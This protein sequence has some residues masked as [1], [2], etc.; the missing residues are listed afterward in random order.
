MPALGCIL[1]GRW[2]VSR[3]GAGMRWS[4]DCYDPR[5]RNCAMSLTLRTSSAS[6]PG[7]GTGSATPL[8]PLTGG[9]VRVDHLGHRHGQHRADAAVWPK[10]DP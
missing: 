8:I 6:L 10:A 5:E 1:L 3:H 7:I 2:P 4:C 9:A